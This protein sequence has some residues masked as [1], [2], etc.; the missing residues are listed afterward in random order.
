[1]TGEDH[2][3]LTYLDA[4]VPVMLGTDDQGISRSSHTEEFIRAIQDYG[5]SW[6]EVKR[7]VR[8]SLEQS[9]APG[10]SMWRTF[11][12]QPEPVPVTACQGLALGEIP[13][14]SC[15]TY[16]NANDKADEQWRLEGRLRRFE[17]RY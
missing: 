13:S 17:S 15:Q 8:T 3:F 4:G 11:D 7:L 12:A 5:L 6:Y 14:A 1:V 10:G 2:P 16:L 9:F